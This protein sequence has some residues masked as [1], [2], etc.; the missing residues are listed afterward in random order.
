[1]LD[2]TGAHHD[3]APHK[4]GR[5]QPF[6]NTKFAQTDLRLWSWLVVYTTWARGYGCSL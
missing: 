3:D 2:E 1:L 5:G 6:A 4:S